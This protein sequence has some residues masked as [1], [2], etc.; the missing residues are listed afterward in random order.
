MGVLYHRSDM[1]ALSM[2]SLTHDETVVGILDR[3]M[4][5]CRHVY[6]YWLERDL[7]DVY[8]MV[9]SELAAPPMVSRATFQRWVVPYARELISLVHSYGKR[10]I[11]HFHGQVR[12]LLPDFLDMAPDG[13]HTIEAPPIGNCTMTQAYDAVGDAVTLIG[14]IQYDDFRALTPGQLEQAVIA[15]LEECRGRRF[16]LSPT[17]GPFDEDPPQRLV[18]NYRVFIETA[19]EFAWA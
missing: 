2:W 5:Q 19:S 6:R 12:E 18:E 15:L 9:G 16:M 14:N 10:V 4:E 11:Q 7:A 13:L 17:A 3:A 8:F 1:A